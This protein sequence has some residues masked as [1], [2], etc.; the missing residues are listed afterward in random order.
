MA[1]ELTC[2]H[3]V[4]PVIVY[5]FTWRELVELRFLSENP[6]VWGGPLHRGQQRPTLQAWVRDGLIEA[7]ETPCGTWGYHILPA[8]RAALVSY[9]RPTALNGEPRL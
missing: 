3:C 1:G 9:L 4:R 7:R 2:P 5:P 8:G 6:G